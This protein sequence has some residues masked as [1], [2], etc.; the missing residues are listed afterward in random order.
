M[1]NN[2]NYVSISGSSNCALSRQ[3]T[4]SLNKMTFRS[5]GRSVSNNPTE[6][7]QFSKGEHRLGDFAPDPAAKHISMQN[8]QTK[9]QNGLPESGDSRDEGFL[10]ETIQDIQICLLQSED[11]L[12]RRTLVYL[13]FVEELNEKSSKFDSNVVP[14]LVATWTKVIDDH[15]MRQDSH[16]RK[17]FNNEEICS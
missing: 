4:P 6:S 13:R 11:I 14:G 10:E 15:S 8:S 9:T 5:F 2:G 3:L 16:P 17:R 7:G 12:Q 1:S